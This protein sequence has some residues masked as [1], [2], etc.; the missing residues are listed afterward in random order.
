MPKA[1]NTS[2]TSR[3]SALGVGLAAIAAGLA[4]PALASTKPDDVGL[5]ALAKTLAEQKHIVDAIQAEDKLLPPVIT[6]ASRDQE[7]RLDLAMD[8]WMATAELIAEMPA[9]SMAGLRVKAGDVEMM[10][11]CFSDGGELW[12]VLARSLARDLLEGS[13]EA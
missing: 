7:R 13:V 4:V 2:T 8:D 12:D 1:T 3:R 9:R 11:S 10:F 6:P 5:V